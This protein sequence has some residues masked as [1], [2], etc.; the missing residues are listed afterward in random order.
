MST[1]R[2]DPSPV[3][4]GS[5]V[6]RFERE[7]TIVLVGCGGTGGFLAEAICRL[8]IGRS[9]RV[10]LVDPDRVEPHNLLR[11][12]FDRG[13]VGRFKAE[14]LAGRLSRRFGRE[15]GYAVLPYT[16]EL[17]G[18]V[19]REGSSRLNLLIG[20]VDNA[21]ARRALADTLDQR[22]YGYPRAHQRVWHLDTG[23]GRN[24]GQVLLGNATRPEELRG[25]FLPAAGLCRALPAPS[26]Q[27]PD[28]LEAQPE[29]RQLPDCAEAVAEGTQG[30][31]I[32]Q[33]VAAI[34]ASF[35]EKM[36]AGTCEWMASYLDLDDG[37]LRCVPAEPKTVATLVGLHVNAVAPPARSA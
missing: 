3:G 24:S 33:V 18:Q 23:N 8:L 27:R 25:A 13:D 21:P 5:R 10:Y 28:L 6:V 14:V 32:N 7:A 11:Q 26:L 17:H 4:D 2:I 9:A 22:G 34:A 12:A 15:I 30:P 19:F 35:V 37:T 1:F 31:T 29:P 16:R 20:C 36:L